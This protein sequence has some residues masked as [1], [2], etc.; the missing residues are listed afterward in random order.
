MAR[1]EPDRST[2]SNIALWYHFLRN[3]VFYCKRWKNPN[4]DRQTRKIFDLEG[5]YSCLTTHF[6]L[7]IDIKA[8]K[9]I[10]FHFTYLTS[11]VLQEFASYLPILIV[12]YRVT[13][14]H[15]K[16]SGC[17]LRSLRSNSKLSKWLRSCLPR[18]IVKIAYVC[19]KTFY[20][21]IFL[22]FLSLRITV[23]IIQYGCFATLRYLWYTSCVLCLKKRI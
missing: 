6:M 12:A 11:Y 20:H 1:V 2:F 19:Y 7:K 15:F 17:S 21:I 23:L 10:I 16:K 8:T 3:K 5:N 22:F 13:S 18:L 14:Y 9:I 4:H